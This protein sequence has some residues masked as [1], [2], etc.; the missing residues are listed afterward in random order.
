MKITEIRR[1]QRSKNVYL[2]YVDEHF[3]SQML[4][5][6]IVKFN[7]KTGALY[8]PQFLENAR[9]ESQFPL[10]LHSALNL[11]DR[12]NK[13]ERQI[14]EYLKEKGFEKQTSFVLE[15]L[16]GYNLINDQK[17]AENYVFYHKSK[18]KKALAFELKLK[19]V[20]QEIINEVLAKITSQ[21]DVLMQL[22][23]KYIKNKTLDLGLKQ[24]LFRHLAGKGFE[25][26]E[27]NQTISKIF[28]K[29]E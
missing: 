8:S 6:S 27:I 28:N 25:F 18:G 17:F 5:E 9:T 16:K 11:L 1:K 12:S 24:K 2:V 15:K 20:S 23:Q 10:A 26:D 7:L 21:E 3:F 13:T 29:S 14:C 19:G 4:D 22:A